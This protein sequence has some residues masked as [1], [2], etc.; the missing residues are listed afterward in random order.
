VIRRA[1]NTFGERRGAYWVLVEKLEGR[2]PLGTPRCRW[3][4]NI[5]LDLRDVGR[6]LG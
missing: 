3:E 2:K 6:G 5:K 4:E 1:C